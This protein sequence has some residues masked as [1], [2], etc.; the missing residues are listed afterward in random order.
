MRL[1]VGNREGTTS[2]AE[3]P[4]SESIVIKGCLLSMRAAQFFAVL[5]R[6]SA[7]RGGTLFRPNV[8]LFR[9][10]VS[11]LRRKSSLFRP[12]QVNVTR[13][14][15]TV[16]L[17]AALFTFWAGKAGFLPVFFALTGKTALRCLAPARRPMRERGS[18][19]PNG[20]RRN[21]SPLRRLRLRRR[22]L[23]AHDVAQCDDLRLERLE[24]G[25]GHT[26]ERR[27][28]PPVLDDDRLL[29]HRSP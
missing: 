10:N 4:D 26:P 29:G 22:L 27:G 12:K 11:L 6:L 18:R 14:Y 2:P 8:S 17:F 28:D 15:E 19:H 24:V 13:A 20:C 9:S 16:D 3:Q 21:P 25:F 5:D 1:K 7:A 23:L